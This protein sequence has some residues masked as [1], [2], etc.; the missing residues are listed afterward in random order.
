MCIY[1]YICVY[2]YTHTYIYIYIYIERKKVLFLTSYL[3][4]TF[5]RKLD[6]CR[7]NFTAQNIMHPGYEILLHCQ[8]NMILVWK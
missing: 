3:N 5:I 7:R 2:I 1:M 6:F 4:H 8:M